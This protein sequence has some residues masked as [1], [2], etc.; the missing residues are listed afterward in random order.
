[1]DDDDPRARL[2]TWDRPGHARLV[3]AAGTQLV[4][5]RLDLT[6]AA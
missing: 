6:S 4:T 5:V 3:E 2:A 1:M